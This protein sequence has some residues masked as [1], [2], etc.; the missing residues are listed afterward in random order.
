MTRS[1]S[2]PIRPPETPVDRFIR[3][4][5]GLSEEAQ[6]AVRKYSEWRA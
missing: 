3:E 4:T 2:I 6:E 1:A 5:P